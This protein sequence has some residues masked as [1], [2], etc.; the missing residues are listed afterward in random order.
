MATV[1]AVFYWGTVIVISVIVCLT[2][3]FGE[4]TRLLNHILAIA[5]HALDVGA[6][7][8]LFWLFEEREKVSSVFKARHSR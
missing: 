6:M 8:P 4:I 5:C 2:A 3:M 7:T 1:L